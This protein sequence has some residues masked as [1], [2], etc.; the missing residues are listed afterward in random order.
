MLL[1]LYVT[2]YRDKKAHFQKKKSQLIVKQKTASGEKTVGQI[3]VDLAEHA[4][5]DGK[6]KSA[7][8]LIKLD[9]CSDKKALLKFV[10]FSR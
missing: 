9:K 1:R 5:K 10:I 4:D 6:E 7:E 8:M 3:E 2:L